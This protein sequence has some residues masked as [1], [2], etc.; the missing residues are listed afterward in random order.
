MTYVDG[1]VAAVPT[2]NREIYKKHAEAAAVV[3]KDPAG[4]R[5]VAGVPSNGW[6]L[7]VGRRG[8]HAHRRPAKVAR[9]SIAQHR[10][11]HLLRG[12]PTRHPD[13]CSSSCFSSSSMPSRMKG[14]AFLY[15]V[16]GS[17]A[18]IKSHVA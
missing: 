6:A 7:E 11:P 15:L 8:P 9:T 14:E 2:A 17:S 18:L 3:F 1:F 13:G 5:R 16:N 12:R 4:S 10:I